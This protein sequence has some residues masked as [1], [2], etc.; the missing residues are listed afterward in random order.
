MLFTNH[1]SGGFIYEVI[2]EI[3]LD[4]I[5]QKLDLFKCYLNVNS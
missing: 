3:F 5:S 1:R 2:N 4:A